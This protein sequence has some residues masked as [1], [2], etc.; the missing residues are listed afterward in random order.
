MAL[1]VLKHVGQWNFIAR[2]FNVKG[3]KFPKIIISFIEKVSP[4]LYKSLAHGVEKRYNMGRM[5]ENGRNFNN[6]PYARYETY[7]KFQQSFQ[8]NGRMQE[9]KIFNEKYT[10]YGYKVEVSVV[11]SGMEIECTHHFP[12]AVSDLKIFQHARR[13]HLN[14]VKKIEGDKGAEEYE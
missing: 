5:I 13:F 9:G 4:L 2:L 8:L 12:G 6:F 14:A 3:P 7:V 1:T 10:L 11:P